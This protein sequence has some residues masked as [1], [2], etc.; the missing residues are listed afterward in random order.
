M[1][2]IVKP[3]VILFS[4]VI[5]MASCLSN[6]DNYNNIIY[7]DDTAITAFS[8]GT[9]NCTVWTTSSTGED[10]SYVDELAGS[11][12]DFYIDQLAR[13]I[14]NPDSLPKGT[15]GAHV[16]CNIST[17]NGGIVGVV[18]KD[19]SGND[20]IVNFSSSDSIDFTEP[21]EFR[22]YSFGG[23]SYRSYKVSVNVHKENPDSFNW[24]NTA[25]LPELAS[26]RGG[27]RAVT[28]D[29]RL[30]VFGSDG[31][32]TVT[33]ATTLPDG[34]AWT[35]I[36]NGTALDADAY[37]NVIT[38]GS[39]LYTISGGQVMMSADGSA[40][41]SVSASAP[42]HL[43]GAGREKLYGIGADGLF[44]VS[45]DGGATWSADAM[46]GD[47]DMMPAD[48][49]SLACMKL[50]TDDEAETVIVVGTRS[51][52]T[53]AEDSS[54]VVWN[55][56][57]EYSPYSQQHSWLFG[58]EDNGCRLPALTGLSMMACGDVIVAFGGRGLGTSTAEP[59][60]HIYVSEDNGLTWHSDTSYT[61]PEGFDNG[62]GDV[63]AATADDDNYI[64]IISGT[65]G[66]V[67]RGRLNRLG[68]TEN[69]TSFTE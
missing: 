68:W 34:N 69:Q 55:K 41:Q 65:D 45:S 18:Y 37:R 52:D 40:W 25:T 48:N 3:F 36:E 60:A 51:S 32:S 54:A 31:T 8:L 58:S 28:L 7:Y 59:F 14:Y 43:L 42:R 13:E 38:T 27:M 33:Y 19:A 46:R 15:D 62:G 49:F 24:H 63:F 35:R 30:L 4:A 50:G 57:E 26:L 5:L 66:Q 12:Y 9:L 11:A 67:W 29:G 6:D 22:V 53:H 23:G 61:L 10:S 21:R 39:A 44:A 64:W 56:I 1:R 2:R 17:K 47:A 20:S 16:L